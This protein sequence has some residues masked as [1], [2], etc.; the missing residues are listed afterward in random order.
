[1]SDSRNQ[2]HT[3]E[4]LGAVKSV[5]VVGLQ[6]GDEG[7]GKIVDLLSAEAD[8]VVRFQGGNN[9][10]HTLVVDGE[11]TV[12]HLIP[13]GALHSD[14]TC[15]IA[16][17]VVVDPGVLVGELN[18]LRARGYL[19]DPQRLR[20]SQECHLI[21]PYHKAIDQARE[22]RRGKG[23]IGTT[24]RGIG[25]AYEDKAARVGV[26]MVDL[27]DERTFRELLRN[28]LEEKNTYLEAMLGEPVL[29]YDAMVDE[30]VG[31]GRTLAEHVTDTSRYL[32]DALVGGQKVLFE[33][34]QG[35][36]LDVDLGTYPFV[37]SS[38]TGAGA[39]PSGAGVAPRLI[40]T[41]IGISKAYTTRVGSGPFPTEL[42]DSI[43]DRLRHEGG[44]FGATT[45]RPRRCGWFDAPIVRKSVRTSGVNALALTK[46]DVLT[47]LDPLKICVGYRLDGKPLD[48]V[49]AAAGL[50]ERVE[51]VYEEHAGWTEDLANVRG[52]DD[53]PAAARSYI[54]RL[55]ELVEVPV[56]IVS[57]G[58]QRDQ[59][60]SLVPAFG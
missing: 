28:N 18:E 46:L 55:E 15:V 57:V 30:L 26:R 8:L 40:K 2:A 42:A 21:L 50:L 17:G 5:V 33:G 45:G 41:V 53:L 56:G 27:C 29:G 22:R 59:T 13:S 9:A 52:L 20:I 10:G 4:G 1:V 6:W 11:Q 60:I 24:G 47:G 58:P 19:V 32:Y 48:D 12:L 31:Y 39:V 35:V 7:K 16:G 54:A 44:E 37:T 14:T 25:P 23:K 38:N 34:A 43:G 36:M 49:P 3:R 51:P